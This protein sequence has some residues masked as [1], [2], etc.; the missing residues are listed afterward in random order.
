MRSGIAV[1]LVLAGCTSVH[2]LGAIGPKSLPVFSIRDNG[3][4]AASSMLVILNSEGEVAA[5]VGGTVQG[6][7]PLVVQTVT[8]LALA[9]AI[10]YAGVSLS[11]AIRNMGITAKG[12]AVITAKCPSP[13]TVDG[14]MV[15]P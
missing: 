14:K 3:L 5:A 2:Q 1:I 13:V 8:G 12:T 7:M 11:D 4:L 9:G 10:G 6:G 15:C